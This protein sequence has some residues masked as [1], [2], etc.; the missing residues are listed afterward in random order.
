[1]VPGSRPATTACRGSG[2]RS[3]WPTV[4]TVAYT[5]FPLAVPAATTSAAWGHPALARVRTT[6]RRGAQRLADWLPAVKKDLAAAGGMSWVPG[7]GGEDLFSRQLDAATGGSVRVLHDRCIPHSRSAIDH[8]VVA[9]S[10]IYVINAKRY[11][12]RRPHLVI[13]AGPLRGGS[14]RLAVG[15]RDCTDRVEAVQWRR[16][17]V[18]TALC[19]LGEDTP[20]VPVRAVL[21]FIDADWPLIGGDLTIEDVSV[22]WPRKCLTMLGRPGPLGQAAVDRVYAHLAEH[23]P[24]AAVPA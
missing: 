16:S 10:G 22:V 3:W 23:F 20:A 14:E 21:C 7:S 19:R 9:A 8:I 13:E 12:A 6:A 15:S 1:M 4:Q 11:R 18:E 24:A 2:G 17:H 5:E